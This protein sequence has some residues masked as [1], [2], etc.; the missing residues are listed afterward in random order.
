MLQKLAL[1]FGTNRLYMSPHGLI[2]S[3]YL[4]GEQIAF[5]RESREEAIAKLRNDSLALLEAMGHTDNELRS[6]IG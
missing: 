2:E 4:K 1:L 3:G 5:L 6:A